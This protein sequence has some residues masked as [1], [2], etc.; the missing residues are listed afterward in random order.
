M[1]Q[2][3]GDVDVFCKLPQGVVELKG[4][5]RFKTFLTTIACGGVKGVNGFKTFLTPLG[6]S[7]TTLASPNAGAKYIPR[8]PA[9]EEVAG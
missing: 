9:L 2:H 6:V 8:L 3:I 1:F 4:V 7:R 5:N